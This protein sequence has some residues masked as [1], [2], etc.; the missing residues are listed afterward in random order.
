MSSMK[1]A[2]LVASGLLLTAAVPTARASEPAWVPTASYSSDLTAAASAPWHHD[3]YWGES[4]GTGSTTGAS[5]W[6]KDK[7]DDGYCVRVK[8]E[9]KKS[10]GQIYDTDWSPKACPMGDTDE[11]SMKPGDNGDYWTAS[12]LNV[13]TYRPGY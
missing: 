11:F 4:K 12:N 10:N 2:G 9:W 3:R 6:V 8:I 13:T 5:G 1:W 7:N